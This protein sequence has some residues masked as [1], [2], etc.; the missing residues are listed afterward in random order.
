MAEMFRAVLWGD[1]EKVRSLM[2]QGSDIEISDDLDMTPLHVAA[3]DDH[4]EVVQFLV[5][6]GANRE[7][8]D[9][10]HTTALQYA[11]AGGHLERRAVLA[12][13]R[14]ERAGKNCSLC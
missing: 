9:D 5:E 10:G 8:T 1:L 3:I 7:I 13:T 2:E 12:A 11:I 6:Q 14:R 4:L